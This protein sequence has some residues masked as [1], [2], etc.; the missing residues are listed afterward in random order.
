MS[1]MQVRCGGNIKERNFIMKKTKQIISILLSLL[2]LVSLMPAAFAGSVLP[3]V[4]KWSETT[5]GVIEFETVTG[6]T[7]YSLEL[8][9]S[10]ADTVSTHYVSDCTEK[11]DVVDIRGAIL[12]GGAGE[13]TAKFVS[14]ANEEVV[15][16]SVEITYQ[17]GYDGSLT[18]L[19]TPTELSYSDGK[20]TWS[21]DTTDVADWNVK[22]Y[23]A[24]GGYEI[25]YNKQ[26]ITLLSNMRAN[27]QTT[28]EADADM[29]FEKFDKYFENKGTPYY[30]YTLYAA[31][32]AT[33][34]DITKNTFSPES[35]IIPIARVAESGSVLPTDFRWSETTPGVVEFTQVPG[36]EKYIYRLLQINAYGSGYSMGSS[37]SDA[38]VKFDN[39]GNGTIDLRWDILANDK[40]LHIFSFAA[41][42]S[43]KPN[44]KVTEYS[45]PVE[46][47]Y[48]PSD[49]Q[50][51]LPMLTGLKYENNVFS[52]TAIDDDVLAYALDWYAVCGDDVHSIGGTIFYPNSKMN[53]V[54]NDGDWWF[55]SFDRFFERSENVGLD[56][57]KYSLY[58][59]VSAY[60]GDI[61]N[62]SQSP[63]SDMIL[64]PRTNDEPVVTPPVVQKHKVTYK[65]FDKV[66]EEFELECGEKI[67]VPSGFPNVEGYIFKEWEGIPTDGIMPDRDIVITAKMILL[68]TIK[69]KVIYN[70]APVK[71]A[72]VTIPYI[73]EPAITDE[74]GEFSFTDYPCGSFVANVNYNG[75]K[76]TV[77]VNATTAETDL[78]EIVIK[79]LGTSTVI[80][81]PEVQSVTITDTEAL[82]SDEDK[83][84]L[85]T[86]GNTI[87]IETKA[88]V[89]PANT[90]I[91]SEATANYSDYTP[92]G[93]F[94]DLTIAKVKSDDPANPVAITEANELIAFDIEIPQV[95]RGKSEYI[96]LREHDGA[97]DTIT[98]NPNADGEYLAVS[99][100][101]LTLYAKKFSVYSMYAKDAAP[102]YTGGGGGGSY[103]SSFTIT[104]DYGEGSKAQTAKVKRNAT[105]EAPEEPT[106]DGFVFGGWYTDKECTKEYDFNSKVTK[107]FT[108]YAKWTEAKTIV[109][110]IGEV[111]ATIDGETVTN[112][113]APVIVNERTMLPIRFIAE[114]LGTTVEWIPETRTVTVTLDEIN[115]SI[116]IDEA[117]AMVN[118][119]EITLDSPAF[120]ENNRTYLPLRFVMEELGADV[121][122][123]GEERTVTIVK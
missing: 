123:N 5:P 41:T 96:I 44:G 29:M 64:I 51:A 9:K 114:A 68:T 47:T 45:M 71:G 115:I 119:E 4:F 50:Q 37:L 84:F 92:G 24:E 33:P 38:F 39:A 122:W 79:E 110:T 13:Y 20:F 32:Q 48:M 36:V 22:L 112:D 2:I 102:I 111:T 27:A 104:F 35:D 30:G 15:E 89:Q 56:K 90:D 42:E 103:M 58:A 72:E 18:A 77:N 121:Q 65:V 87:V 53:S 107:S 7:E 69:G 81:A 17:Y 34:K 23:A 62:Y 91:E 59:T 8:A 83:T 70:D 82:L 74:N 66:Y 86:P 113:V 25:A 93:I 95:I 67:P 101:V 99:G 120:I 57:S 60:P 98:K 61:I 118:G 11:N 116:V 106:K 26:E 108:L 55:D 100:N 117:V 40:K 75:M 14:K 76:T 6:V 54:D 16:E 94:L 46:Y 28:F 88:D 52:W 3:T 80:A 78:G 63:K 19:P 109:L 1:A 43:G 10:G 105:A 73:E 31:V 21:A 85:E 12:Q 49:T 97:V